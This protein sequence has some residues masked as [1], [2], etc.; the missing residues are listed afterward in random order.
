MCEECEEQVLI[1]LPSMMSASIVLYQGGKTNYR[2]DEIQIL[3]KYQYIVSQ[4]KYIE[5]N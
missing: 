5:G 1:W 4:I 3:W 2:M